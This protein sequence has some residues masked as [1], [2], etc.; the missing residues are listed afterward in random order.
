MV[1]Q[2]FKQEQL[3]HNPCTFERKAMAQIIKQVQ[4][5]EIPFIYEMKVLNTG[6]TFASSKASPTLQDTHK[7]K[8]CEETGPNP[9]SYNLEFNLFLCEV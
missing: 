4:L 7:C 3:M 2:I 1:A 8:L 5:I 6:K 9:L